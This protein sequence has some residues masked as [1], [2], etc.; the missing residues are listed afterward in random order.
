[1]ASVAK[2]ANLFSRA[3]RC[4]PG[5]V[6]SP[7]R[8]FT[9]VGGTPRFIESG[10]GPYITDVDGE[11]YIDFI[12]SWGPI[13]LGHASEVQLEALRQSLVKGTSFGAPTE[14]E[15]LFAEKICAL[16]PGLDMVRLV[17]SG[18][19]AGMSAVRLARAYTGRDKVIKCNGCY[20]GHADVFLV[21]AGSGVATQGI[22]GSPGVPEEVVNKTISVEFNDLQLMRETVEKIGP[23]TIAVIAV[24]PV[25]G[26]MGLILPGEGY[27]QG[28]RSLCDEYGIALL[29]DEVM[30]GFRVDLKGATGVYGV[31]PDLYCFG[32]VIGGG[33]PM[34]AFGG[35]REIM[36]MLAPLGPVYQAGTLSGNP[37]AVQAGL[38]TLEYLTTH[39]PYSSMHEMS[40]YLVRGMK[41]RAEDKG[42]PFQ[43]SNLG[44]MFGYFF[45]E[46]P[47][48]NFTQAKTSNIPLFQKFFHHM[49]ERGVYFAPSAFEAGFIGITHTK[50]CIDDVLDKVHE[51]FSQL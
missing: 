2:S 15:V 50:E 30:S 37:L 20:H 45:N 40:G 39:N 48:T 31:I 26:N 25:P 44:S 35:K 19:E 4:I 18:T 29:F 8:A 14:G 21:Q 27:L 42:I 46:N 22:S 11:R 12:G 10:N 38:A 43:V 47:V 32:K 51:A 6:N 23:E 5:G 28:L 7:V 24:E 9:Q 3:S 49:L 17:S 16:I 13:I 33:L 36:E 34:A 1:M 41:E